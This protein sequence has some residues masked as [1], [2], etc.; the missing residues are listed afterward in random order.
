[1]PGPLE[2]EHSSQTCH[3]V[4][5]AVTFPGGLHVQLDV[6][7]ELETFCN[8][9]AP[10]AFEQV[11]I[12]NQTTIIGP[13][14]AQ[15]QTDPVTVIAERV[16][17]HGSATEET[18]ECIATVIGNTAPEPQRHIPGRFLLEADIDAL[19]LFTEL[20]PVGVPG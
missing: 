11:G 18:L 17:K 10:V 7:G 8:L 3:D 20:G 4:D 2:P 6:W 15:R 1:M 9:E 5:I 16:G 12:V 13:A 14:P 19:A